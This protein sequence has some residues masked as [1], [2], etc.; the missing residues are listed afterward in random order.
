MKQFAIQN[1]PSF[2]ERVKNEN[3]DAFTAK[4]EKYGLPYSLIFSKSSSPKPLLKFASTEFRRRMLVGMV[5]TKKPGGS[6]LMEKFGVKSVPGV[7]V[8]PDGGKESVVF[9]KKI[10]HHKLMNFLN[11]Y[12]LKKPVSGVKVNKGSQEKTEM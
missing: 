10:S 8:F 5:N 6:S 3:I 1:M 11:K 12:A 4:A 9:Q 2:I 7:V